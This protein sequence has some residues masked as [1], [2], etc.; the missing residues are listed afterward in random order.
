MNLRL[1]FSISIFVF[2]LQAPG[3][4]AQSELRGKISEYSVGPSQILSFDPFSGSN[5]SWA[6]ISS[7]GEF[8]LVL[9]PDFLDKVRKMAAE[10]E[11]SSPDGFRISFKTV[12][13]TFACTY[14]EVATEGG[15]TV[16]SGLPEL[17][18]A[19]E[20]QNPSNGILYAVSSQEMAD[21]LY[22]YGEGTIGP[23]YY[24]QFYFLE[25]AAKAKGDCL[26]EVFTGE[27]DEFF[28]EITKIDLDLKA[29]WNII[30]YGIDEVFTSS[31]GKVF[32]SNMFVT[33][34]E[35]LPNDLKWIAV[36][37]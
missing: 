35:S 7:S 2:L 24:L 26:L 8:N 31:S 34:L 15:E 5:Q 17:T 3:L 30:R 33:R 21:W 10:A 32:P 12:A 25:G 18:V 14:E 29:G 20:M 28:E 27:G 36:K 37:D 19:D 23:G 6:E 9:E 13:E 4:F 22:S 16:V 1:S 11:K